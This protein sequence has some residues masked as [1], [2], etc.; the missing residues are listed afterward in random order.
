MCLIGMMLT[1]GDGVERDEKEGVEW[2]I[3][4]SEAGHMQS[5]FALGY[6]IHM[7]TDATND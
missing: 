7:T 2:F 4:G 3:K 1:N 5:Q 6:S